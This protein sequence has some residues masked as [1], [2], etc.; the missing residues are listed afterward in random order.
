MLFS[1]ARLGSVFR[2]VEAGYNCVGIADG[3]FGN[4]APVWHKEILWALSRG[5][6][7][8]GGA[9]MGALRA[10]E[11]AAYGMIGVGSAYRLF[12][13]GVLTDDDEV[14]LIHLPREFKYRP[15]SIPMVNFRITLRRMKCKKMLRPDGEVALI[16]ELKALHFSERT[17]ENFATIA[18]NLFGAS[19]GRTL[20][21]NLDREYVDVKHND[22]KALIKAMRFSGREGFRERV[23]RWEF[24][25]THSWKVQF[26]SRIAEIPGLD[27]Y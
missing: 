19:E 12:R 1:P 4:V 3:Y 27:P 23:P 6:I 9:S 14:C 16:S 2:A 25:E 17:R 7:V 20:S 21:V 18:I 26:G 5:V 22:C 8:M 15:L 11:L 13:H 24:P 10:A